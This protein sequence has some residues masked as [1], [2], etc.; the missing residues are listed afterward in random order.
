M[1]NPSRIRRY[2]I[3]SEEFWSKNTEEKELVEILIGLQKFATC[4]FR[5]LRN[6]ATCEISQVAK[7]LLIGLVGFVRNNVCEW[8]KTEIIEAKS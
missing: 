8:L 7:C 4:K 3:K 2:M 6:L 1:M 5:R